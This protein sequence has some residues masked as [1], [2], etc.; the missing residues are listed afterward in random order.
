MI[1]VTDQKPGTQED[2][3]A[4]LGRAIMY[5]TMALQD[6]GKLGDGNALSLEDD[7]G[8]EPEQEGYEFEL[9]DPFDDSH[10]CE[11]T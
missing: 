3:K 7:A 10:K 1:E 6:L 9:L 4:H 11:A 8:D 5:T 2:L